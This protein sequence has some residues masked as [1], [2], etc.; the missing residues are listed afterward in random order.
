MAANEEIAVVESGGRD[1]DQELTLTGL[2]FGILPD[3]ETKNGVYS[4]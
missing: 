1:L 2:R 3:L 4:V